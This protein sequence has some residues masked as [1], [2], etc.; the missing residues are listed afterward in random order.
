[1]SA[2]DP[3]A[4]YGFYL[5]A[6]I[7]FAQVNFNL[8]KFESNSP[9]LQQRIMESE[10]RL[11]RGGSQSFS[12]ED[13]PPQPVLRQVLGVSWDVKSDQ[14]IANVSDVAKLMKETSPSIRNAI[15]LATRFCNPSGIISPITVRFKH[16][17]EQLDWDEPLVGELL[18]E[19]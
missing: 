17:G 12:P 7:H 16:C 9:E 19:W 3:E 14:I 1:M 8:R 15:S 4:A 13:V 6:K 10:Q 11:N 18:T 2:P 5:R